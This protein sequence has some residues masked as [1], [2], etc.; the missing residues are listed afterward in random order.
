[1]IEIKSYQIDGIIRNWTSVA[2]QLGA[3]DIPNWCLCLEQSCIYYTNYIQANVTRTNNIPLVASIL[4]KL[5]KNDIQIRH[6]YDTIVKRNFTINNINTNIT[7]EEYLLSI[8]ETHYYSYKIEKDI[9]VEQIYKIENAK[10]QKKLNRIK[11]KCTNMYRVNLLRK[12]QITQF[13]LLIRKLL[14]EGRITKEE[15]NF[16][17]KNKNDIII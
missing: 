14:S 2:V 7:Y 1:M 13:N 8:K 15:V 12:Y 3:I 10:S 6:N 17:I 5:I 16:Y 9:E 4:S 11:S